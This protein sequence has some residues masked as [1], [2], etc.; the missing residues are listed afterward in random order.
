MGNRPNI[1]IAPSKY[2]QGAGAL[3][4]I[5]SFIAPLGDRVL[6]AGGARGLGETRACRERSFGKYGISQ[7]EFAFGGEASDSEI[8]RL[9]SFCLDNDF[10]IIMASGGGKVIDT[11]K[12]AAEDSGAAAV[13]VPTAA[14][15]DA[16]CSALSVIYNDDGT[17]NRLRP[18]KRNPDLVLVDT[19][20]IARAPVRFLVAGIGDALAT[21]FEA[22]ACHKSGAINLPGGHITLTGLAIARLCYDTLIEFSLEAKAACENKTVNSALEKVVEANTLLS[23]IGFESGGVAVAHALS[24][25]F[26]L[27]PEIHSLMHGEAVAFGLL[28]QI[29]LDNSMAGE[30]DKVFHLCH[31]IGLPVTLEDMNAGKTDRSTLLRAAEFSAAPGRLSGNMPFKVTGEMLLEAIYAA[32][33]LGR[34]IKAKN[35]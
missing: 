16:P 33:A 19:A 20:I 10:G 1:L 18:L 34:A 8:D 23:G 9:A 30:V 7:A 29:L 11:V 27:I 6:V 5:G 2:V 24:E 14:S 12:A 3:D 35:A 17:F 21:W 25:G 13:V 32:D 4:E 22:D 31:S 28:A 15:N 26:S